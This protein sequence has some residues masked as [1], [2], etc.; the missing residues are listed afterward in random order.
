MLKAGQDFQK[1]GD[2][3]KFSEIDILGTISSHVRSKFM[4]IY[5][6]NHCLDIH[7]RQY[8]RDLLD[9]FGKTT[10]TK[11]P[12]DITLMQQE[13]LVIKNT[14]PIMQNWSIQ[15]YSHFLWCGIIENILDEEV[16]D[17]GEE[18]IANE[19][20]IMTFENTDLPIPTAKQLT[21]GI[22]KIQEE[23]LIPKDKIIEI[24]EAL[25]IHS[26]ASG[27]QLQHSTD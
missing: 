18:K 10:E 14:H 3:E 21:S 25:A 19:E 20:D 17:E 2:V 26:I 4:A 24:V 23:L 15:D 12:N 8:L 7:G 6:P 11:Y 5:F 22:K 27:W 9:Y 16:E 1:D 13:L